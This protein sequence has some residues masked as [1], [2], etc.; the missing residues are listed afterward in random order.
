MKSRIAMA[1]SA[2]NRNETYFQQQTGIKY[3]EEISEMLHVEH[4]FVVLELD[5]SVSRTE[6]T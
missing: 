2:F 5:T 1:T 6:V 4:R 3:K